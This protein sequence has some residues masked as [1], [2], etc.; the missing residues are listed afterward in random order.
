MSGRNQAQL[1]AAKAHADDI[2]FGIFL[3]NFPDAVSSFGRIVYIAKD[4]PAL[5]NAVYNFNGF[6]PDFTVSEDELFFA[7][8]PQGKVDGCVDV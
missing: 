6:N 8:I 1:I 2:A 4:G 5:G 3:V 7:A